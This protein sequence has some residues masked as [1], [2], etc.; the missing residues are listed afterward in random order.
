MVLASPKIRCPRDV[1]ARGRR[2]PFMTMSRLLAFVI[3]E[4]REVLPP[5]V[6]FAVSFNRIVLTTDLIL[7]DY[8]AS[9]GSFM[10]ATVT[11]LVVGKA[12]LVA[13]A[14]PF[15]R[16]FDT[17]PM[18]QPVLFKTIVYWAT[19]F[20]V[21][22]LEKLVEYLFAGGTLQRDSGV[23]GASLHL[24]SLCRYP[25]L[26]FRSVSDLHLGRRTECATR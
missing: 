25:D 5:T 3:K 20:L 19:V 2:N 15:L 12:V 21:R 16:R 22:F 24:A 1:L 26:D 9:F 4:L 18:I 6:F 7:A 11:A 14:M 8:L 23:R 10:V 17:A 13:N